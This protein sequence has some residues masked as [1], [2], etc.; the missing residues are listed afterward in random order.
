M[1][2]LVSNDDGIHSEGIKEL[3]LA[4]KKAG[5]NVYVSAPKFEQSGTGHGVTLHR[6]LRVENYIIDGEVFGV[7]IDGTPSDCVKLAYWGIYKDVKFDL[8][9]SGINKG[10]NLGSDV[11]Y[12]GTVSAA[13]EGALLGI[14]SIAVSLEY[15][16]K[17]M[18]YKHAAVFIKDF[19]TKIGNLPFPRDVLLNVNVP[20]ISADEVKGVKYTCQGDRKYRDDFIERTDPRGNKYYWLGGEVLE[21]FENKEQNI[22][23]VALKEGYISI[24]PLNLDLTDR[25]FLTVI[26]KI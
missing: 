12:S 13:A 9:I 24:T 10:V 7:S 11:L 15:N 21:S 6:P 8:L 22:D 25:S 14:K 3:V 23:F 19:I 1:N 2:I 17:E 5:H 20:N 16:E 26:E 4:L 18:N